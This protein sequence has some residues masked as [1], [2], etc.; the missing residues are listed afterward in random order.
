M[1]FPLITSDSSFSRNQ[2][3]VFQVNQ[4]LSIYLVGISNYMPT[5]AVKVELF[6]PFLDPDKRIE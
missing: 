5:A 3:Q 4:L 1:P 2:I 6:V